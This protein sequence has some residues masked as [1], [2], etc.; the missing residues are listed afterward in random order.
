MENAAKRL[1]GRLTRH[2]RLRKKISGT[3]LRPRLAV[4]RSAM[5]IYVQAVD[6]IAGRT[7]AASSTAVIKKSLKKTYTGNKDAAKA[8]GADVAKKLLDKSISSVVFD[9]GGFVYHGRVQALAEGARE[10]GLKF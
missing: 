7:I 9:R 4:F 3:E 1:K 2:R 10:A 6:D 5:H 8:V